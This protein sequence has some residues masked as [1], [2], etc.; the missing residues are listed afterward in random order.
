MDANLR[1]MKIIRN[2]MLIFLGCSAFAASR[3]K[4]DHSRPISSSFFYVMAAVAVATMGIALVL[5]Q[6]MV[7]GAEESLRVNPDDS[8]AWLRWRAGNIT[9]LALCAAIADFGL[10]VWF[11]EANIAHAIP[12]FAVAVACM[13]LLGPRRP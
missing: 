10:V 8:S 13:L 2:A 1:F 5:K 6:R 11:L 9:F 7:G 3:A 4:I 12:F